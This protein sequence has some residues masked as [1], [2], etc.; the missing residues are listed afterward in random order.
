M[1]ILNAP[2]LVISMRIVKADCSKINL[3][4]LHQCFPRQSGKTTL[5]REP[6]SGQTEY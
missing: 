2:N 3:F 4:F 1:H 5:A 6:E